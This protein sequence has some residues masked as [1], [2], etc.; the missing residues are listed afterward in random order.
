MITEKATGIKEQEIQDYANTVISIVK[1]GYKSGDAIHKIEKD[2][3][4][5]LLEMGHK[6]IGLLIELCGSGDV[7]PRVW[8]DEE[9]EVKRLSA[10]R[11]KPYLSIFGSFEISRYVYGSRE[12]QKI[13]YTPLD[14][15][16]QL[17]RSKFSY[18]L[19]DWDQSLAVE[20]PYLR[21]NETL[22]RIFELTVPVH[23][24]ERGN[25]ELSRS[26]QSYW[27]SQVVT[28]VAEE[29]Q[30]VVCSADC[31]GVVIRKSQ[32][33][34]AAYQREEADMRK[35]ASFEMGESKKRS[36]KKKMAVLG[37]AYTIG[38]HVRTPEE[39][40]KSLFRA[41]EQPSPPGQPKRP[42]PI[43]KHI[44]ASMQRD[45]DDTLAP[46]RKEIFRWLEQQQQQR[47]PLRQ[48]QAV[49]IMDGEEAL[50]NMGEACLT[51]ESTVE[52]L[53]IIHACSYVWKA[54]QALN[55]NDTIR[56]QLPI[57]KS[58]VEK[59]LSGEIHGLIRGL[60]WKAT[61]KAL[62]GERLKQIKQACL[63][64]QN[65]AQRMRYNEYLA[66]GYQIASGVIEGA[67]RHVVVDRMEGSGMRWVIAGA[68]SMLNLRCVYISGHWNHFIDYYID[69][70]Q[71]EIYPVKAA[72]DD[73]FI[74]LRMAC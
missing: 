40:L 22:E 55:P 27:E 70:E 36:G 15:H 62:V 23:S 49:L 11:V 25:R 67:C 45:E 52:I 3:F 47:N 39:I 32:E 9:R 14:S 41:P 28:P 73:S 2:L 56:N 16:L 21:V 18:L 37:A 17:P 8:L 68:Q 63:Y 57:V 46:A 38:A 72:N 10:P 1:E 34:Q 69:S 24:L 26:T 31:K 60:R 65:N 54:V 44:R 30:I 6:A 61:H 42:K 58:Y 7:G 74:T 19:Q 43:S 66:A 48:S 4:K 29:E 20:T 33:E 5:K 13:E 64:F 71:N 50:W 12:G 59:I 51:N 53:D 35:P